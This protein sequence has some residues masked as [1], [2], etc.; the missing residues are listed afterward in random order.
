MTPDI[1]FDWAF[2]E[3][4][5][6]FFNLTQITINSDK[7][8]WKHFT[9]SRGPFYCKEPKWI[10]IDNLYVSLLLKNDFTVSN[11]IPTASLHSSYC[12]PKSEAQE[13][14]SDLQLAQSHLSNMWHS[15]HSNTELISSSTLCYYPQCLSHSWVKNKDYI[16]STLY[17][18]MF[19]RNFKEN[20]MY[21]RDTKETSIGIGWN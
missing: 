11:L 13:T 17:A 18:V 3:K 8:I 16:G 5:H 19:V 10:L 7:L 6:I 21:S 14:L 4:C 9:K 15:T 2:S 20:R 1:S 12:H